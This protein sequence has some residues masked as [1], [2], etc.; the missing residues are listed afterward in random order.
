MTEKSV[1]LEA[2]NPEMTSQSFP[3]SCFWSRSF[4][5]HLNWSLTLLGASKYGE[6]KSLSK[7]VL[8]YI[9]ISVDWGDLIGQINKSSHIHFNNGTNPSLNFSNLSNMQEE[10]TT[11]RIFLD[12]NTVRR[13]CS[14]KP[15]EKILSGFLFFNSKSPN[16]SE[17]K[18]HMSTTIYQHWRTLYQSPPF[19]RPR[20]QKKWRLW[21]RESP[22]DATDVHAQCLIFGKIYLR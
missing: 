3:V 12:N 22:L 7:I 19:R 14:M 9:N 10:T 17:V 16:L 20:D 1:F 2:W 15:V 8:C 11:F 18:T 6:G 13:K 21:E 5:P 4:V